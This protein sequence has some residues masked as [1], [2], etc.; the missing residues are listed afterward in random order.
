MRRS[1][2]QKHASL[3][4]EYCPPLG[5]GKLVTSSNHSNCFLASFCGHHSVPPQPL[6]PPLPPPCSSYCPDLLRQRCPRS[7][8]VSLTSWSPLLGSSPDAGRCTDRH[9]VPVL[10]STVSALHPLGVKPWVSNLCLRLNQWLL[11]PAGA[12]TLPCFFLA[13]CPICP[14][15]LSRSP[16]VNPACALLI[17]GI[18]CC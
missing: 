4:S 12:G 11:L 16:S 7:L 3:S 13:L 2:N 8:R 18:Q 15:A 17:T 6:P 1:P 5:F 10:A 14:A 9:K